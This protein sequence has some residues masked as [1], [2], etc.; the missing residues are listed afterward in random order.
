MKFFVSCAK[1]LEYLLVDEVQSMGIATCTATVAGVNVDG[2]LADAE[3]LVMFSR[4]ASRVLWPIGHFECV[5]EQDLYQGVHEIDWSKH[6]GAEA[7]LSI[8]AHVSSETLTH[9]RYAAQRSKDA[10]VDR[11]RA[12]TGQRP[13]VDV[14]NPD[15]R[16]NVHVRKDKADIAIDL[17]GGSLHKRGWRQ[18]QGCCGLC[19]RIPGVAA[20][21]RS[22]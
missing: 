6:I 10:I 15:V 4:L 5:T 1:G 3:R 16:I 9:E 19:T 2:S 17:G 21:P 7:T 20:C 8:D 12:Q 11:L 14:E 13:N 22:R 18:E